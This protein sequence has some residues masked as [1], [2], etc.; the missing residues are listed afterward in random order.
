MKKINKQALGQREKVVTANQLVM[1]RFLRN[2]MGIAGLVV[3]LMMVIFCFP[4]AFNFVNNYQDHAKRLSAPISL[5]CGAL[6]AT[7][8]VS[9]GLS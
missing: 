1:R 8:W 7:A 3:L 9:S 4:M 6:C 5:S 2:R